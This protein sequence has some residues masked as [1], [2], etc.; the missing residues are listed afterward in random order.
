MTNPR[1]L[2]NHRQLRR[3]KRLRHKAFEEALHL[4]GLALA[5]AM[6]LTMLGLGGVTMYRAIAKALLS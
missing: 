6:L 1:N 2:L 5:C 4:A 3:F